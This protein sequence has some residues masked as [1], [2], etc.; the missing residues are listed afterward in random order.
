M[1]TLIL[2]SS[3]VFSSHLLNAQ[4][5]NKEALDKLFTVLDT[6]QQTMGTIHISKAGKELY[7]N[8]I[9]YGF[10]E[11]EV[12]ANSNTRYRIGS[13]T[14]IFT[15]TLI[16]QLIDAGKV[17]IQTKLGDF[18]PEIPNA[19]QITIGSLLNH[20][21][22]IFNLT[23][24][25]ELNPYK[26][27]TK[28]EILDMMAKLSPVFAPDSKSEYSN[29]NYILLGYILEKLYANSYSEIVKQK[30]TNK[31]KLKDT[32]YGGF[33][34]V[35]NKEAYSYHFNEKWEKAKETD[36]SLPHGAGA[37]VS[38][39][40]ELATFITALF[41]NQLISERSLVQMMSKKNNMG[42]GLDRIDEGNK[43]LC[44][45]NGV[46]D[47]FSSI[48]IFVPEEKLAIAYTANGGQY[49]TMEIVRAALKAYYNE[50]YELPVFSEIE[51]TQE[52]LNQY[53]GLYSS[54]NAPLTLTFIQK[55][56][57]LFGA[58]TGETPTLLKATKKHQF[59]LERAG[60]TLDF[61]PEEN[62]LEFTQGEGKMLFK[63]E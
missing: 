11:E 54:P 24:H 47:G 52:E 30:I 41:N 29:S 26:A 58:P 1:K 43:I 40:Q 46:I 33:I 31:L 9:G 44:G 61:I 27:K 34:N 12:K 17:D 55:D 7:S 39:P 49:S 13:L 48:L 25:K 62:S 8:S 10:V 53:V 63:K 50:P 19:E 22:G 59:K 32:Y 42:F 3:L 51:I 6:N 15:A 14:K 57:K 38:T 36:M 23:Q 28:S 45:H 35:K 18:Y 4:T 20:S 60:I 16:F 56:G 2:I 21:S 5:I 37:L